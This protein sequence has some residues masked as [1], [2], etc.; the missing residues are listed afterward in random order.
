MN[1]ALRLCLE[2]TER[3]IRDDKLDS[4]GFV[5]DAGMEGKK[6]PGI[7]VRGGGCLSACLLRGNP[8]AGLLKNT[9][10]LT[11]AISR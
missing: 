3:G 1:W 8:E 9:Q 11:L 6:L 4:R 2:I 7:Q 10:F 5:L